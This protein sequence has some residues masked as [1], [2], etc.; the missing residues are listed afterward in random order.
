MPEQS[1]ITSLLDRHGIR[2]EILTHANAYTAQQLA[3]GEHIKGRR[4]A[5]VVIVYADGGALMLVLPATHRVSIGR[6]KEILG[7]EEVHLGSENDMRRLFP[8]CEV[9]AEPPLLHA[10]AIPIW[11]DPAMR[12]PKQIVFPA[13]NHREAI[14]IPFEAWFNLARPRV[15]SFA[16][17]PGR[18]PPKP[19]ETF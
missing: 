15:E 9:G 8:D 6:V 1:W 12:S 19:A 11:L 5:K 18:M 3:H 17:E 4:V 16:V 10:K 7:D 13:G 14:R 2:Y